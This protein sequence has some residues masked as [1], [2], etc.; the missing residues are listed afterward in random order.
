MT[1]VYSKTTDFG[2]QLAPGQFGTEIDNSS[3]ST[4]LLYVEVIADV[5]NVVFEST[6]SAGDKTT[7]DGLVAS[8]VPEP[9]NS[10]QSVPG[11]IELN[12][13]LADNGAIRLFASNSAGG[14]DVDAGLGG[15]KMDTTNGLLLGAAA[16]SNF[17]TTNGNL[18][19]EATNS[20]AGGLINID[21][22]SGLNIGADASTNATNTP[23]INIGSSATAKTITVGNQTSTTTLALQGG[24]G[25]VDI[26]T[27]G[28]FNITSS[29]TTAD[30]IKFNTSG[31][32]DADATGTINFSTASSVGGAITLDAAFG[33]GGITI[34]SGIQGIA[35]NSNGG[36][37][38]IGHWSGGN[39]EIGTAAVART[40][41]L[42]NVTSTTSV[43]LNSGTGGI[44]I[45]NNTNSGEIQIGNVSNAKTLIVGNNTGSS[46]LFTRWGTGGNVKYQGAETSLTD[47][48][49]TLTM[50]HLLTQILTIGPTANRTLTMPTAADAV[51]AINNVQVNDS[52]DFTILH[53]TTSASDPF[54]T[55][56]MGS[57]GS[58]VGFL[59]IHPKT[60]N[61]GTYFGSGS[62]TFRLRYTNVTASS[63]AYTLYRIS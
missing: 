47:S 62:A 3:I 24:T 31:G 17:T 34:S 23:I 29:S 30:A 58:S 60:N 15:I 28:Q 61:A 8:H 57:G 11:Y 37:I 5:V 54:I 7:L 13:S 50:T 21:A 49:Q 33:G 32:I 52:I 59:D 27:T 10:I 51:S 12:S 25:G 35:V 44:T 48:S 9:T 45:G 20:G 38:G 6:I 55:L 43:V 56:A 26:D 1:E 39:V 36:L 18:E 41:T 14:I 4:T 53:T 2:G 42:G 40:L 19:L 63:E 16:A 46:R 22:D